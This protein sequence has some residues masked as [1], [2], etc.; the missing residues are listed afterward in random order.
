MYTIQK[1]TSGEQRTIN[2]VLGDEVTLAK[3]QDNA[4]YYDLNNQEFIPKFNEHHEIIGFY[5]VED[6]AVIWEIIL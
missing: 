6:Q 4:G 5:E 1:P 3:A 2:K